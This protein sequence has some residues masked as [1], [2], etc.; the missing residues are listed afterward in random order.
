MLAVYDLCCNGLREPCEVVGAPRLSWRLGS[1][2]TGTAQSAY[3]ITVTSMGTG[4]VSWDSGVVHSSRSEARYEGEPLAKGERYVWFV[5]VWD[6]YGDQAYGTPSAFLCKGAQQGEW[7]VWPPQRR[8]MVWT[9]DDQLNQVVENASGYQQLIGTKA[10]RYVWDVGDDEAGPCEVSN[11]SSQTVELAWRNVVGLVGHADDFSELR[12]ALPN[13]DGLEFAQGTLLIPHGL[14]VI[15]WE[16]LDDETRLRVSIPPGVRGT[17]VCGGT[18]TD[19]VSG[20]HTLQ[21]RNYGEGK[22]D[23]Q[24]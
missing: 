24:H 23:E 21:G 20:R 19:F 2:R 7:A 1:S 15:R 5:A 3:R 6:S 18:H 4:E 8:G 11:K 16:F 14:L 22:A 13:R 9:S 17:L 10:M 12:I